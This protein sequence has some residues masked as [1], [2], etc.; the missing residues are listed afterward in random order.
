MTQYSQITPYAKK[1][2]ELANA[3]GCIHKT[4]LMELF[5]EADYNDDFTKLNKTLAF[6]RK[7]RYITYKEDIV[8][9]FP[10]KEAINWE[11]LDCVWVA[12]DRCKRENGAYCINDLIDS[13]SDRPVSIIMIN[14]ESNIIYS[15]MELTEANI[16]TN[17]PFVIGK[18]KSNNKGLDIKKIKN[19]Q[20]IFVVKDKALIPEVASYEPP[21]QN[22]IALLTTDEN[23]V[24]NVRY[25]SKK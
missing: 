4:Q 23:G 11:R 13:Y 12:M 1:I 5:R 15:I 2:V 3:L 14:S 21:M 17:L 7:N 19:V 10:A 22:K 20:Y 24:K 25:L 9:P 8:M 18:F 16:G 6:L